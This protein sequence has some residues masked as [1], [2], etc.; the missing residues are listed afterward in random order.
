M[1]CLVEDTGL[2][3]KTSMYVAQCDTGLIESW[4]TTV[5]FFASLCVLQF[6]HFV[7]MF[8]SEYF[9]ILSTVN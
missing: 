5:N 7:E 9:L 1:G 4:N 3:H 8:S 6:F 2:F